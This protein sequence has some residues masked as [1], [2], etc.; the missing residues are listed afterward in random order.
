MKKV[1]KQL[2]SLQKRSGSNQRQIARRL[3]EIGVF[4]RQTRSRLKISQK[5]GCKMRPTE[6]LWTDPPAGVP[7]MGS[8]ELTAVEVDPVAKPAPK[9]ID[10]KIVF[11]Q[12][13]HCHISDDLFSREGELSRLCSKGDGKLISAQ[14]DLSFSTGCSHSPF[15]G[16][17]FSSRRHQWRRKLM[18][19]TITKPFYFRRSEYS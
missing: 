3:G 4:D 18:W 15:V 13:V 9:M 8:F 16:R 14:N 5:P 7:I 11:H 17:K 10:V 1:T 6:T 19:I 2:E 12:R